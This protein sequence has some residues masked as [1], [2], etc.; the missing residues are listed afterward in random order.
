MWYDTVLQAVPAVFADAKNLEIRV[1]FGDEKRETSG[2]GWFIFND[3]YVYHDFS[4]VCER[5]FLY[6]F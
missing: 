1:V 4:F 3:K 5:N 2:N 6:M